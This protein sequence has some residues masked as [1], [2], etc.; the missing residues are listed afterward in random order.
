MP[1]ELK[2]ISVFCCCYRMHASEETIMSDLQ[3]IAVCVIC[4]YICIYS[5]LWKY[6]QLDILYI[7]KSKCHTRKTL[8]ALRNRYSFPIVSKT[9][10]KK[11]I[12]EINYSTCS[13]MYDYIFVLVVFHIDLSV[14]FCS[15]LS[16]LLWQIYHHTPVMTDYSVC[17][18]LP[19]WDI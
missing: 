17:T 3:L 4:A 7:E 6:M 14:L 13:V 1:L 16:I 15:T 9:N 18:S 19:L 10:S 2:F 11:I 12:V 8:M 5:I